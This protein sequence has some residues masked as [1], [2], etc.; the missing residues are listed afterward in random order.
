M[1][2]K[3]LD[4]ANKNLIFHIMRI[5]ADASAARQTSTINHLLLER[6]RTL[7]GAAIVSSRDLTRKTG[8]V[9]A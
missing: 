5:D 4:L 8:Q 6:K 7:T 2:P 9:V 3:T 1:C